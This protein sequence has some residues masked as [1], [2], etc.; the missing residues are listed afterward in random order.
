MQALE[1][2]SEKEMS[3]LLSRM[4]TLFGPVTSMINKYINPEVIHEEVTD[5]NNA[6]PAK[7]EAPGAKKPDDPKAK[8]PPAKQA[9][10]AKGGKP[11]AGG[12]V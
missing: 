4:E 7:K 2:A 5:P 12:E 11:G 6:S 9:A 10:P 8:A 3:Q 1:K